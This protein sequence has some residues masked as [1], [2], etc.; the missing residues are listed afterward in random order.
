MQHF[1]SDTNRSLQNIHSPFSN[2]NWL[3]NPVSS[4]TVKSTR[5]FL[6]DTLNCSINL[7]GI[8]WYL[9]LVLRSTPKRLSH[10][11]VFNLTDESD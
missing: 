10:R 7:N 4:N 3:F 5:F 9:E 8:D 1:G 6:R 2:Y 11:F